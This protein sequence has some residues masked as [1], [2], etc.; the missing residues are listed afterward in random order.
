MNISKMITR[1]KLELGIYTIALP[2]D[3]LDKMMEDII[4]DI[5]LP[6]FSQFFPYTERMY[7]D[8]HTWE[9]TEHMATYDT[10]LIPEFTN[11]KLLYVKDVN[12]DDRS[13]SGMGYWGGGVPYVNGNLIHQTML[14][15]AAGHL[16][17]TMLPKLT[18][19]FVHPRTLY[20]Y[21][22]IASNNVVIDLA[23]E[24]DKSLQ[25]IPPTAE[26]S[27]YQFAILDIKIGLY[28]LVKH[29][30]EIQTAY[31]SINLNISDWEN[32]ASERKEMIDRFTND[33]HL[34]LSQL[35]YV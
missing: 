29:Y 30:N 3:N 20:I 11:R 1:M 23:F 15:N 19:Q 34:D 17:S 28:A 35:I 16:V 33:F 2:I 21:N 24:H 26:E 9:R 7:I 27:F 8:L 22:L 10:F 32:A 31:G 4:K 25:S 5:S 14:S 13:L 6:V 12:Y 18:F